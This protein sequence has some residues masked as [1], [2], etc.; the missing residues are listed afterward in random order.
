MGRRDKEGER[1][2]EKTA[3]A[4]KGIEAETKISVSLDLNC[5]ANSRLILH[6]SVAYVSSTRFQG[7]RLLRRS[8]LISVKLKF[9]RISR[10]KKKF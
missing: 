4:R 6:R 7:M 3:N 2:R 1:D 10:L 9:D 8:N 5:M